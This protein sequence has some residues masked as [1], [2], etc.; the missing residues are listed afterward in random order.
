MFQ[1]SLPH[2][3]VT[4]NTYPYIK[5]L[6]ASPPGVEISLVHS[7]ASKPKAATRDISQTEKDHS[8]LFA[9]AIFGGAHDTYNSG[10]NMQKIDNN[11]KQRREDENR[12]P[13]GDQGSDNNNDNEKSK[14]L[15]VSV[16]TQYHEI[17][18]VN[19]P[20]QCQ[21]CIRKRTKIGSIGMERK[22]LPLTRIKPTGT[23]TEP[24]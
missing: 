12:I 21:C 2:I 10:T 14:V 11:K 13:P 7:D 19:K 8:F 18:I 6:K 5:G 24:N 1:E 16:D 15:Q 3:R 22:S 23:E 9:D 4:E 20:W 17:T